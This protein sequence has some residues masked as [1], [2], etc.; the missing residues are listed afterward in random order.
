MAGES[1]VRALKAPKSENQAASWQA[2][3]ASRLPGVCMVTGSSR[4]RSRIASMQST[5]VGGWG[6][7]GG[8]QQRVAGAVLPPRALVRRAEPPRVLPRREGRGDRN[9]GDRTVDLKGLALR[10]G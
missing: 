8:A 10:P 7:G 6:A 1:P 3:R 2:R 4:T 5:S 9:L